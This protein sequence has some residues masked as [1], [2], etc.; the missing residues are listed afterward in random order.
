MVDPIVVVEYDPAWPDLFA[1]LSAP[2]AASLGDVA[3]AIEHV[4]SSAVP[5]LA[6]K[7]IIDLDVAIRTEMRLPAAIERLARLGY[8]LY[9]SQKT[10]LHSRA[11]PVY[12][13]DRGRP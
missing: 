6:A 11:F 9:N 13:P 7:P 10:S 1:A 12:L 2:V 3:V 8:R 4:G 5:G